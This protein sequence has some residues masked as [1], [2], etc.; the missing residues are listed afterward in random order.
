MCG[1][2]LSGLLAAVSDLVL[3]TV[4]GSSHTEST[5][6]L[7][8]TFP[9][10]SME[11]LKIMLHWDWLTQLRAETR[12][13]APA[14]KYQRRSAVLPTAVEALEPRQLLTVDTFTKLASGLNGGPVL[15][16]D[17][18]F[19]KSVALIGD[20]N[21]DGTSDLAVG[22]DRDDTG[23]TDKGALYIL[24]M[25]ADG[26]VKSSTKIAN[27][28]NGGPTLSNNAI[29]GTSVASLGDL[30]GDGHNDL[31]VGA[32]FDA[33]GGENR[34]ALYILFLNADGT[35]KASTQIAS[36][37]NGG[38]TLSD[39]NFFGA[40]VAALG[41]VNG[42]SH[43]DIAVG[44]YGD[45]T[46]QIGA[47][48]AYVL[49]LNANG[50][51]QSFVKIANGMN[52]APVIGQGDLFGVSVAGI[53][54]LNDD[55]VPDLAVGV[56]HNDAGAN[57]SGAV[58]ILFLNG[59]GTVKST[60][61]IANGV[62]GGPTLSTNDMFGTSVAG[63]GDVD[64]DGFEDLAVGAYRDSTGGNARGA[65]YVVFMNDDGTAKSTSKIASDTGGGPTL[66]NG[67]LFGASIASIG[68][69]NND[70]AVDLAVGAIFDDT[71]GGD[72]GALHL[73]FQNFDNIP[74][75][76]ALNT[77]PVTFVKKSGPVP[78]GINTTLI[79]PDIDPELGVPGG[80]LRVTFNP[81]TNKKQT[82]AFDVLD[83]R[84][85]GANFVNPHLVNGIASI[86]VNLSSNLTLE[87]IQAALRQITFSTKGKGLKM[88]TRTVT[89]QVID[90]AG[91]A[92]NV[93]TQTV[94]VL[95]KDHQQA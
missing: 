87:Q 58:D 5:T 94:N 24:F 29:F 33:T 14:R 71:A 52:G 22:A 81:V 84:S 67:D 10:T 83:L 13:F 31:A 86:D 17:D 89:L 93:I 44:A 92:S 15:S 26:S 32:A 85:V 78:I 53:G 7:D 88:P 75:V 12:A 4:Y 25:N 61:A 82:K 27:N 51:A 72:R 68:D 56:N 21:G 63:L 16:N 91:A 48:A 6:F 90:K 65:A 59:D 19:G 34:G 74:P 46:G 9:S 66:V 11:S 35:V 38:P 73:L 62:N 69:F 41:D 23:G 1:S 54:D 76:L 50:T 45:N 47:G 20:L 36:S 2:V 95:K 30:D 40:S 3:A 43:M 49:F 60:Q 37:T 28:L 18:N 57:D 77:L 79:D 39:G 64:G 70:G 8:R 80:I 42:D 55:T